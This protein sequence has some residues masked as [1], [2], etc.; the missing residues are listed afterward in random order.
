MKAQA[1]DIN[2]YKILNAMKRNY[3]LNELNECQRKNLAA[4]AANRYESD[5]SH[6]YQFATKLQNSIRN[7]SPYS[8]NS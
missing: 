3:E 2:L 4:K 6:S 5:F 7:D 8:Y 1:G